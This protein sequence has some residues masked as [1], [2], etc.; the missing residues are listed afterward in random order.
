[1][2]SRIYLWPETLTRRHGSVLDMAGAL[3]ECKNVLKLTCWERLILRQSR[4]HRILVQA[5]SVLFALLAILAPTFDAP[6]PGDQFQEYVSAP[7]DPW[8][9]TATLVSATLSVAEDIDE[10]EDDQEEAIFLTLAT[11]HCAQDAGYLATDAWRPSFPRSS[12]YSC[13][14][15]PTL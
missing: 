3:P 4:L 11:L 1:M 6:V 2:L 14:G 8:S 9:D 15:P 5:F 7:A 13:T 10:E 12:A